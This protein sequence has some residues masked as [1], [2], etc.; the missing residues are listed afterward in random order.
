METFYKEYKRTVEEAF[1]RLSDEQKEAVLS[2]RFYAYAAKP[3]NISA[4][5]FLG[6]IDEYETYE[7][8]RVDRDDEPIFKHQDIVE[9]LIMAVSPNYSFTKDFVEGIAYKVSDNVD[10]PSAYFEDV[11]FGGCASGVT[12]A[13]N[14]MY[15]CKDFYIKHLDDIQRYI[16]K[17]EEEFGE[18]VSWRTNV[19]YPVF[20]YWFVYEAFCDE[21]AKKL[22]E[23]TY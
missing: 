21:I 9:D 11:R 22:F 10:N 19:P 12:M 15:V 8:F 4:S 2:K 1:S 7:V 3:D 6:G 18:S 14:D 16:R 17:Y 20:A 5:E 23:E 13:S